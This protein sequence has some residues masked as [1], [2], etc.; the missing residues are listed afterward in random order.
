MVSR[1]VMLT[2]V[3]LTGCQTILPAPTDSASIQP[4]ASTA[5]GDDLAMAPVVDINHRC[6]CHPASPSAHSET[7]VEAEA[8][9]DPACGPDANCGG[10][11]WEDEYLCDGG[12]QGVHVRVGRRG[13]VDGLDPEDTVAH[14]DTRD[15]RTL[16]RPSNSVC[17]Y[18]PRFAAVRQVLRAHEDDL[19]VAMTSLNTPLPPVVQATPQRPRQVELP[20]PSPDITGLRGAL[21]HKER[22]REVEHMNAL[23]VDEFASEFAAFEDLQVIRLGIYDRRERATLQTSAEAA[24]AWSIPVAPE[25]LIEDAPAIVDTTTESPATVHHLDERGTPR[26][27]VVKIAS[28]S[29]ALPG[30]EV[31]FTLRFDNLGDQPVS[32]V[33]LIDRLTT[34]LEYVPDSA[35]SSLEASFGTSPH[36][37]GSLT[38]Q[39]QI[40]EPVKPGQGGIIR[41]RCKVR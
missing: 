21:A 40:R 9:C 3:V 6:A 36:D 24:I 38:L 5:A 41:F 2:A 1:L 29:T 33:T 7:C 32:K 11:L 20:L 18:A 31:E 27:R 35:Q 28:R 12:D 26:L 14:F 13:Q 16:V 25:V 10:G 23:R 30:E 22:L 15:G 8:T 39:W 17:I 19:Q 37:S 4:L 34:R